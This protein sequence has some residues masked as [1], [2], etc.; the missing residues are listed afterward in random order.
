MEKWGK[1]CLRLASMLTMAALILGLPAC[2]GG[3][4]GGGGGNPSVTASFATNDNATAG[5]L[6]RFGTPVCAGN[7]CTVPILIGATTDS[8]Y[9]AFAFDLLLSDPTV[10]RFVSGSD[11]VGG[12]FTSGSPDS[13]VTQTGDRVVVGVS[14]SGV[15]AG[16][17]AAAEIT[18]LSLDFELLKVGSTNVTF[19]GIPS[20]NFVQLGNCTPT[21]PTAIDDA[22]PANCILTTVF[23]NGGVLSGS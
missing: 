3:G 14:K 17:G 15:V 10:A 20:S 4:G 12:F 2:G 19:Q 9:Y 21:G 11:T 1:R 13:V 18:V 8:D 7:M 5:D 6:V 23:G 16:N 22:D